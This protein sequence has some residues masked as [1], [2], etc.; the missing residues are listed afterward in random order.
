LLL[1][2]VAASFL[3]PFTEFTLEDF[4]GELVASVSLAAGLL[5]AGDG[6]EA[7]DSGRL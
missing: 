2:G 1:L 4:V 7:A 6:R 3:P 5:L